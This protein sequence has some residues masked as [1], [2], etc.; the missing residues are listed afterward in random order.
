MGA[1]SLVDLD[2]FLATVAHDRR[3]RSKVPK[4]V[5]IISNLIYLRFHHVISLLS[6]LIC[7]ECIIFSV[8]S[9]D[10]HIAIKSSMQLPHPS[11]MLRE[12]CDGS[13]FCS[14]IWSG[15]DQHPSSSLL[16]GGG[17]GS[18]SESSHMSS[19]G[20][21]WIGSGGSGSSV[22]E[23]FQCCL[24]E[25]LVQINKCDDA[26]VDVFHCSSATATRL[27]ANNPIVMPC[28]GDVRV[29]VV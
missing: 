12:E 22:F 28:G 18:G 2:D 23:E 25:W 4:I 26:V 16:S 13:G 3:E 19:S 6:G 17:V 21:A 15:A 11:V 1:V 7:S 10:A 14:L 8:L 5:V 27:V 24:R 29:S 9:D 20:V